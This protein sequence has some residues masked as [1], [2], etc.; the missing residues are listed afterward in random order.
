[1]AALTHL[2]VLL[3]RDA[4]LQ[5]WEMDLDELPEAVRKRRVGQE[6][7]EGRRRRHRKG[8]RA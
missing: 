8:R 6:R 5:E 7:E 2:K 4:R 1:M 3:A